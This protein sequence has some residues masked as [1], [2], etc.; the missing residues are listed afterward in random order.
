MSEPD[1][2]MDEPGAGTKHFNIYGP[3]ITLNV[4]YDDVDHPTVLAAARALVAQMNGEIWVEKVRACRTC[5]GRVE[6]DDGEHV[7]TCRDCRSTPGKETYVGCTTCAQPRDK[8]R[9]Y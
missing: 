5:A 9:A 4:D 8:P 7:Y 2:K 1:W 3:N 6:I